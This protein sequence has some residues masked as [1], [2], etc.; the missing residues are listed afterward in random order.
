MEVIGHRHA[1]AAFPHSRYSG[2]RVGLKV[3]VDV[4]KKNLSP[5]G[6][7]T[8]DRPACRLIFVLTMPAH[9]CCIYD[10]SILLLLSFV[11]VPL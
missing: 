4:L 3:T 7:R 6:V 1:L 2:T 5:A 8:P 10:T 11:M 9:K